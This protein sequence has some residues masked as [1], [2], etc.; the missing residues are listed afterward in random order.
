MPL[1]PDGYLGF[2]SSATRPVCEGD[3]AGVIVVII[4]GQSSFPA[5]GDSD[6]AE[7]QRRHDRSTADVS[8]I[9]IAVWGPGITP[10][11]RGSL[12]IGGTGC[13]R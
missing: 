13:M 6:P 12:V 2:R 7:A 5:L 9:G 1:G 4:P 11:S 10:F 8:S 3:A